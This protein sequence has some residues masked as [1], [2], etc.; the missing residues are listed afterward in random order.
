MGALIMCAV[1]AVLLLFSAYNS[2]PAEAQCEPPRHT[3][4][5]MSAVRFVDS[6]GKRC[7]VD[8]YPIDDQLH[9]VP[10]ERVQIACD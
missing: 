7:F 9:E 1:L 5:V 4:E 10:V 3:Q 2:M 6:T 8:F